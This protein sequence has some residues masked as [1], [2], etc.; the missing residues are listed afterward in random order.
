[1]KNMLAILHHTQSNGVHILLL[2]K[3]SQNKDELCLL[4][5][6]D[7]IFFISLVIYLNESIREN[8]AFLCLPGI[9]NQVNLKEFLTNMHYQVITYNPTFRVAAMAYAFF[10]IKCVS[11]YL[12]F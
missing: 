12:A 7:F 11:L 6:L 10:H 2:K 8:H 9:T 4:A 5:W 1:M 3:G